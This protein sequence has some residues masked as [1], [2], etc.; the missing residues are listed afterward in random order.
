[1]RLR[2][3]AA[4]ALLVS[5]PLASG[6]AH[7]V[8]A[9]HTRHAPIHRPAD[10]VS[11]WTA[12]GPGL[13]Q[14]P[15]TFTFTYH[16]NGF[17]AGLAVPFEDIIYNESNGAYYSNTYVCGANCNDGYFHESHSFATRYVNWDTYFCQSSA[18]VPYANTNTY[19]DSCSND[20]T[21]QTI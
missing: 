11:G 15:A 5:L 14:V 6:T 17:P 12:T 18:S 20:A 10:Q 8:A 4:V 1:M 19:H 7:A 9:T 2:K 13:L 21:F 16:F 3:I